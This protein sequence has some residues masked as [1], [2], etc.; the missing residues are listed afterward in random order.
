MSF[1]TGGPRYDEAA[2]LYQQASNQFKLAKEWR[3]AANCLNQC[4]FCAQC[5]ESASD[6]ANYLMEAGNVLKKMS[7]EEAVEQFEK[8]IA[9]HSAGG[10]F[11][12]AGKLL[13]QIAE[14]LEE[15]RVGDNGRKR[16]VEY[17]KRATDLFELDDHSKSNVTKCKLQVASHVALDKE[18]PEK[19][20]LEAIQIFEA[21]GEK[22][23]GNTLL[24]FG[25][26]EHFLNAGILHLVGGD[27]VTS[28]LANEKYTTLDPRFGSSREG[29]L[30]QAL[31]EACEDTD[32]DKFTETIYAFESA[33]PLSNWKVEFLLKVKDNMTPSSVISLDLT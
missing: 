10:R 26:K 12:Q 4:A 8:A 6:Q 17:Y 27:S 19:G 7:T 16:L 23:L 32:V 2:E 30:L 14:M 3:E 11:Q 22:A 13:L 21:E 1:L 15:Q 29:E 9:I 31:V 28:S 33:S 18:E 25:A 24:S 5:A 20:R